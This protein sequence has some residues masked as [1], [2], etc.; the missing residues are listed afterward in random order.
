MIGI[1][2]SQGR[3]LDLKVAPLY[4][5]EPARGKL[6]KRLDRKKKLPCSASAIID[7]LIARR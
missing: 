6:A 5:R 2:A 3:R 7:G 1:L 4:L